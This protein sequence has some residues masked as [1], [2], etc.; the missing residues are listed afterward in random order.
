MR[1]ATF[2]PILSLVLSSIA[3]QAACEVD[4]SDAELDQLRWAAD[5]TLCDPDDDSDSTTMPLGCELEIPTPPEGETFDPSKVEIT[6]ELDEIRFK[7]TH[8]EGASACDG[9][10]GWYYSPNNLEPTTI[11]LCPSTCDLVQK[12]EKGKIEVLLGCVSEP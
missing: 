1:T 7:L 9:N 3:L 10:G 6:I 2:L 8:V 11:M 4:S 12:A 5:L